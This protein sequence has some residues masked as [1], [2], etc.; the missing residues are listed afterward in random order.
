VCLLI[1]LGQASYTLYTLSSEEGVLACQIGAA[2][3]M[4]QLGDSLRSSK[5]DESRASD[6]L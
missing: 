3:S 5:E 6:L 4:R 2:E 1:V